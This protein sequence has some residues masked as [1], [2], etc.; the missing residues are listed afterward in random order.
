MT[1]LPRRIA[2][3]ASLAAITVLFVA[4]T[5]ARGQVSPGPLSRAHAELEGPLNCFECHASGRGALRGQCLECHREIGWLI[6]RDRG[7][8]GKLPEGQ[9]CA[10]CHPEHAGRDFE[11]V[12]WGGERSRFDHARTGWRLEGRHAQAR[13]EQCHKAEFRV[14]PAAGLAPAA[15]SRAGAAPV[16]FVGLETRCSACHENRHSPSLG[17]DCSRC[18]DARGW[19][20][21]PG[22]DHART[23]FPLQGKH[24]SVKCTECHRPPSGAAQPVASAQSGPPPFKPLAHAACSDCHRDPHQGRL[25][26]DCAGC[27]TTESFRKVDQRGFDHEKTRYPL[28]GRHRQV[29]CAECHDPQRG[30]SAR[31]RFDRC[32]ACHRDQ[33]AGLATLQGRPA[34][35][36]ECHSVDGY[37]PSTF[38]VARHRDAAYPLDGKHAQ[39][40]CE[41]CHAR[42]GAESAARLGPARVTLRRPH[43]RCE[44]CHRDAHAGQLA[45]RAGGSA[46]ATCHAV[47]GWKPSRYATPEHA[48]LRL[49]LVGRHARIECAAC[50]GPVR[51]RAPAP[52]EEQELGP[53]RVR[54]AVP[55]QCE[56]CHRD[57]HGGRFAA[58]GAR[59][60]RDGCQSCHGVD[61]FRV[62]TYGEQAHRGARFPLDGAHRAIP[63]A[64]C[65]RELAPSP[66]RAK[67]EQ[68]RLPFEIAGQACADC[69]RDPHAGQFAKGD[70]TRCDAC[71]EQ[72][73]F[74][75]APRFRHDRTAFPLD[76]AHAK[77]A[78]E[79]CHT[80]RLEGGV[81][82]V[83]YR[84][85]AH[86]CQ[87]C[88]VS[89]PQS[90]TASRGTP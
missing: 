26:A 66:A 60:A 2:R 27:H 77:V 67:P 4:G 1:L 23:S 52:G 56:Q 41:S 74:R 69:H 7:L 35:C 29:A 79:K 18:H 13:C 82:T 80:A 5:P 61:T 12:E 32:D 59:P 47:S 84:P 70:G 31:P 36:G 21:A 11:L 72:A 19:R 71:H 28:R 88:H 64:E 22:F 65:H 44:D 48:A 38:T 51:D 25:G 53:A 8:H 17:D 33:H 75:P 58:A 83:L 14:S 81:R 68:V 55:V 46:C 42:G 49:P 50:H 73:A 30:G 24:A 15:R 87:D 54:F 76:G 85:L 86:A 34:D 40:S 10:S 62:S 3:A 6:E 63:C 90:R 20:P 16:A 43:A 78:C 57:P 45:A 39:V 9:D 89:P 37:R